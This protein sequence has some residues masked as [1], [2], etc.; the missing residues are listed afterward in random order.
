MGSPFLWGNNPKKTRKTVII[1]PKAIGRKLFDKIIIYKNLYVSL[2][3]CFKHEISDKSSKRDQMTEKTT[4]CNKNWFF[5]GTW[6]K[7]RFSETCLKWDYMIK[8]LAESEILCT[9]D[10]LCCW[11][12]VQID[13]VMSSSSCSYVQRSCTFIAAATYVNRSSPGKYS[14]AA[15]PKIFNCESDFN[16]YLASTGKIFLEKPAG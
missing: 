2:M 4:N 8:G 16:F 13:C 9:K 5:R 12:A 6:H 3:F 15:A 10:Q 14:M 1:T 11:Q 7:T